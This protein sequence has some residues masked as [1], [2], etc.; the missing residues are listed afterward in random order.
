MQHALWAIGFLVF[1]FQAS[2]PSASAQAFGEYGRVLGGAMQ[3]QGSAGPRTP[4]T[5]NPNGRVKGKFQGIG[6]LGVEPLQKGLVVSVNSA[7][8][9]PSQDDESQRIE[10]LAEGTILVPMIQ[11]TSGA[12][13]WYMVKT[14]QGSIGWVKSSDV[15]EKSAKK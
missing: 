4:R 12:N 10:E 2:L 1:Y 14:P 6:N 15:L 3:R 7:P 11:A 9:Y 13:D 5:S 8:L